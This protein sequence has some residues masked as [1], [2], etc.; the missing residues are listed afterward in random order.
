MSGREQHPVFVFRN[1]SQSRERQPQFLLAHTAAQDDQ[2]ADVASQSFRQLV[3]VFR[4][5][6]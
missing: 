6:S 2:V 1:L 3:Q 4:A 5:F